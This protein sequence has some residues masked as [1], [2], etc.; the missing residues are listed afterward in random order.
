MKWEYRQLEM[1]TK[2]FTTSRI[3]DNCI[4]VLNSQGK[5][6]WELIQAIPTARVFGVL[7]R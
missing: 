6:D 2:G 7:I 4:T 3:P 5:E 1:K